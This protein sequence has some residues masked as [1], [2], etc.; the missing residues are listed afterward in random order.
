MT[1]PWS[2]STYLLHISTWTWTWAW[3]N[4]EALHATIVS[5]PL[6]VGIDN[7]GNAVS[8]QRHSIEGRKDYPAEWPIPPPPHPTVPGAG[9]PKGGRV[10]AVER[11]K[12]IRIVPPMLSQ[13]FFIVWITA[14]IYAHLTWIYLNYHHINLIL[15]E[16]ATSK[17][18]TPMFITALKPTKETTTIKE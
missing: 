12:S 3:A 11:K 7:F 13:A 18:Q 16:I 15:R 5:R 4:T 6:M 8:S 1:P 2:I 17:L 14:R 9:E 10:Q